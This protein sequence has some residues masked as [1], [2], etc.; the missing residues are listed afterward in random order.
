MKIQQQQRDNINEGVNN[1]E[2]QLQQNQSH[3][4]AFDASRIGVEDL[5]YKSA[6]LSTTD[7]GLQQNKSPGINNHTNHTKAI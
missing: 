5:G 1:L 6:S 4:N 7:N 2:P 3:P